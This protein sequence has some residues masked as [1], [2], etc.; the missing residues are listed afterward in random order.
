MDDTLYNMA[1]LRLAASIPREGKLV[2]LAPV[3]ETSPICGSRVTASAALGADGRVADFA[4]EV[5]ACALGQASAAV[6]GAGVIGRDAGELEAARTGLA[7]Y[8]AG[9]A[10]APPP[11]WPGLELFAPARPHRARH[12]SILLAFA[13]AARAARAAADAPAREAA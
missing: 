13:A 6:L 8:L 3:I 12:G 11:G 7:D 10:D 2:G 5:R 4:Q 9:R 1:I